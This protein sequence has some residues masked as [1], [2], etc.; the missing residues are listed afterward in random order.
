V[1]V[2]LELMGLWWGKKCG[3]CGLLVLVGWDFGEESELERLLVMIL[4]ET[5]RDE[6][7]AVWFGF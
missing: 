2:G 1:K 7:W 6:R 5:M 4:W 3:C